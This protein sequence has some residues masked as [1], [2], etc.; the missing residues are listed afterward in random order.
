M[1]EDSSGCIQAE[2]GPVF[3]KHILLGLGSPPSP[4]PHA[5]VAQLVEPGPRKAVVAGSIPAA[6]SK[7]LFCHIQVNINA[8]LG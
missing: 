3:L 1:L 2:E 6:S 7:N 4:H 5:G 8:P